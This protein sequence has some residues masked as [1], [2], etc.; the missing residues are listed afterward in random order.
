MK[1]HIG[2]FD[3]NITKFSNDILSLTEIDLLAQVAVLSYC[4]PLITTAVFLVFLQHLPLTYLSK[5]IVMTMTA[6]NNRWFQFEI[7]CKL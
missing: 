1:K 6:L 4:V 5:N 2:N 7:K 3:Y